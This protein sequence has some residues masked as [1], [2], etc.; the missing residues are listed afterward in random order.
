MDCW[1]MSS[2]IFPR[3]KRLPSITQRS[4]TSSQLS[5]QIK[6]AIRG[7]LPRPLSGQLYPSSAGSEN[8][9]FSQQPD[10][11]EWCN[12][13]A[14][15]ALPHFQIHAYAEAE[16]TRRAPILYGPT[17]IHS[18]GNLGCQSLRHSGSAAL[19]AR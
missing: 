12:S 6:P 13:V 5:G 2:K 11:S 3:R 15:S 7:A 10:R 4:K 19:N 9:L 8:R 16:I 1:S 14:S 17:S 18:L